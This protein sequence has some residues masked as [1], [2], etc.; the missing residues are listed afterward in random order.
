M[1]WV[2]FTGQLRLAKKNIRSIL[3]H[4]S[5]SGETQ[6]VFILWDSVADDEVNFIKQNVPKAIVKKIPGYSIPKPIKQSLNIPDRVENWMRQ[7]YIIS[8]AFEMLKD[9]FKSG[10]IVIR[11]RTDLLVEERINT[12]LSNTHVLFPGVKFGIGYTDYIAIMRA[13][14]LEYYARTFD[15]MSY[16]YFKEIFLPPEVLLGI[17]FSNRNFSVKTSKALPRRLLK[18]IQGGMVTRGTYLNENSQYYQRSEFTS[19]ADKPKP[20]VIIRGLLRLL[21]IVNDRLSVRH[22]RD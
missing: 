16:Y 17:S 14:F 3:N 4:A 20:H 18:P 6:F 9:E 10:D 5:Y 11:S 19:N 21:D 1:N 7:Y 8:R 22:F 15:Y 12:G 13:P 2:I